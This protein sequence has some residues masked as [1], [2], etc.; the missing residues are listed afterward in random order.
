[1]FTTKLTSIPGA[2]YTT[3]SPYFKTLMDVYIRKSRLSMEIKVCL[4]IAAPNESMFEKLYELPEYIEIS[5]EVHKLK[6]MVSGTLR[7]QE[8]LH[9]HC[10]PKLTWNR[11]YAESDVAQLL[12]KWRKYHYDMVS[13]FDYFK[14]QFCCDFSRLEEL[15]TEQDYVFSKENR[16]D[17]KALTFGERYGL[18]QRPASVCSK[19]ISKI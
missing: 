12:E 3:E 4:G 8:T 19:E 10:P 15:V 14:E 6:S 5:Q 16:Q 13:S 2:F 17:Y 18:M 1:M 9:Y 11:D 7:R